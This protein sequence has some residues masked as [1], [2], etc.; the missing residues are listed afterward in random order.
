[1]KTVRPTKGDLSDYVLKEFEKNNNN[2]I[3]TND[4]L[5]DKAADIYEAERLHETHVATVL[6]ESAKDSYGLPPGPKTDNTVRV[7]FESYNSLM[8]FGPPHKRDKMKKIKAKYE[9]DVMCGTEIGANLRMLPND[10]KFNDI[11][12]ASVR[13]TVAASNENEN[14][15]RSIPGGVGMMVLGR[16]SNFVTKKDKDPSG[17]GDGA[18]YKL[19][20]ASRRRG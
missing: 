20:P 3:S 9:P 8:L 12:A 17:L 18:T 16:L 5:Y 19:D 15:E 13:Q 14:Y 7:I 4:Q 2:E 1:M 11:M 10:A 6:A